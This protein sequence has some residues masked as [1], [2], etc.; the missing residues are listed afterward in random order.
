MIE[1]V[2]RKSQCAQHRAQHEWPSSGLQQQIE[3]S[4]ICKSWLCTT[5]LLEK[6]VCATV[7]ATR[8]ASGYQQ[9]IEKSMI[10]KPNFF[11]F[12]RDIYIHM[13]SFFFNPLQK[14]KTKG[15][16]T[17]GLFLITRC[18][19]FVKYFFFAR[20]IYIKQREYKPKVFF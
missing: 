12:A 9:Q 19:T 14:F 6:T 2:C 15:V 4:V 18:I 17:K 10:C 1:R 13:Y 7:C 8:I 5:M 20:D 16:Q 3:K 11:C